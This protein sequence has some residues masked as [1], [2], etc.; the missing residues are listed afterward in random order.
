MNQNF[1][2]LELQSANLHLLAEP[3]VGVSPTPHSPT[4]RAGT[5]GHGIAL[6]G[7]ILFASGSDELDAAAQRNADRL[8]AF[9]GK[10]LAR[11]AS[12][13]G[14]TDNAGLDFS[15]QDLSLRRAE[16]VECYLITR[17]IDASR[18]TTVGRGSSCPVASNASLIGR[19]QNRR[20]ELLLSNNSGSARKVAGRPPEHMAVQQQ[21]DI[22]R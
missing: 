14:Y 12:I 21:S 8:V 22:R 15:N 3:T 5:G 4:H 20:A 11:T 2:D 6:T 16:S 19:Q 1:P 17:G 18:L 13:E 7:N 9:L 10:Y